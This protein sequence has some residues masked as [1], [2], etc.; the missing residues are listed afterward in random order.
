MTTSLLNRFFILHVIVDLHGTESLVTNLILDAHS[1]NTHTL[2]PI[3][4]GICEEG[5]DCSIGISCGSK[6]D[7]VVGSI[8]N[9]VE[10]LTR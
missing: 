1:L 6:A 10:A 8:E 2:G 4:T 3:R 5:V 9:A 7:P